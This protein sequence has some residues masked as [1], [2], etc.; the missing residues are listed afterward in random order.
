[1]KFLES[2]QKR[3]GNIFSENIS[4]FEL[5]Y[6]LTYMAATSAAGISRSRIF[7]LAR[8][9]PIA[10][11]KYFQEIHNLADSLR[12]NYP[13]A[14]RAVG[15]RTRS[16]AT[17][18]FLLRL[19]DTLS[20][21]EPLAPFLRR[22]AQVLGNNYENEYERQIESLKKWNDGYIAITVSI[23]L[24][25]VINMVSTIIYPIGPVMMLGMVFMAAVV[26]FI[27]A[28]VLSRAAPRETFHIPFAGG[29]E[30]QRFSLKA[31]KITIPVVVVAT[32]A[33]ILLGV[34]RGWIMIAAA[35]LALPL[36]LISRKIETETTKKDSEVSAFL[37]SIG[38]TAT[39]RG[40]TLKDAL[41]RMELESF[42][43]LEPD[44]KRLNLRLRA[45]VK[46]V[47]C[48]KRFGMETGSKLIKQAT[49]IFYEATNLGGDPGITGVLCSEFSIKTSM[50]RAK[51]RGIAATFAWLTI[52]MHT[53]LSTLIVF[54]LEIINQ[55]VVLLEEA[56]TSAQVAEEEIQ[57]LSARMMTFSV[58]ETGILDQI[59]LGMIIVLVL[60]NAFAIVATEG[61]HFLKIT[62]YL[63]ILLFL[64][65]VS[66]FIGPPLVQSIM[67]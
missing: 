67:R 17:M 47:A 23:A 34:A 42:P 46:P 28:F 11:A 66:T 31:L 61:S 19:S 40:T 55:F 6:Q 33:L 26:G 65:G 38:G 62:F 14:C 41:N 53:V 56:M 43:S 50:L 7:Q 30:R 15:G 22:E 52:A 35:V 1:V 54:L 16:E 18:S 32:L 10:P 20:S 25:V 12:Y 45:L 5:F 21:G 3:T 9:L 60:I 4:G 57:Q 49:D 64:S 13:D 48:W 36:G 39:S 59:A 27:V 63:S 37:R 58:P 8:E 24:I 29:S 51:R 2:L 44:V